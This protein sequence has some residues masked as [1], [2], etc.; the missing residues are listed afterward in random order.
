MYLAMERGTHE[1]SR[2]LW[3]AGNVEAV[4]KTRDIHCGFGA[5]EDETKRV[6]C[7]GGKG[8]PVR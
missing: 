2:N 6:V 7:D 1:H 5:R 4:V 3:I 8:M